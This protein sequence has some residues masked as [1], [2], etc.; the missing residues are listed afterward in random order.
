MIEKDN[1]A[2]VTY[3]EKDII[4]E[5]NKEV[6][7]GEDKR[8]LPGTYTVLATN[9]ANTKFNLRVAG[10]VREYQHGQKIV[11]GKGDTI[12]AVSHIVILR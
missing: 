7:V 6:V 4:L 3:N 5:I 12:T 1:E 11:L 10:V 2:N 8:V 9:E